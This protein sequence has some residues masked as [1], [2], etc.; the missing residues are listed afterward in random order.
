MQYASFYIFVSDEKGIY[1]TQE[2]KT[3]IRELK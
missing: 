3:R 1:N 2:K